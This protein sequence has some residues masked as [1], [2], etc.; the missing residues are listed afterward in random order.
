MIPEPLG[1]H[2][3]AW[4]VVAMLLYALA[5]NLMWAARHAAR[6][7]WW[8]PSW[9]NARHAEATAYGLYMLGIP[10]AAVLWRVPGLHAA[11]LGL[12]MPDAAPM[13]ATGAPGPWATAAMLA[14][15]AVATWGIVAGGRWWHAVATGGARAMTVRAPGPALVGHV[16]LAALLHEAH[17]A[18]FR[19]GALSLG[20][21]GHRT[22]GVFLGLGLLGIEAWMNPAARA[23]VHD[24]EALAVR[25]RTASLAVLSALLFVLTG[26]TLVCLAAHLATGLGLAASGLVTVPEPEPASPTE[27]GAIEPT[28]V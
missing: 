25:A 8:W 20:L 18:F 21:G 15:G 7:P 16:A 3:L 13:A 22:A 12:P 28:V 4:I 2:V 23:A 10:V 1:G 5:T 6:V 27:I 19:A 24:E 26:N 11:N 17:W 9:A 14:S